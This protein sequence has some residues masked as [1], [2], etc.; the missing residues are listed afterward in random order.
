M[1]QTPSTPAKSLPHTSSLF[2]ILSNKK[3]SDDLAQKVVEKDKYIELLINILKE[4]HIDIPNFQEIVSSPL[5]TVE[6]LKTLVKD[7]SIEEIE[8]VISAQ[9]EY[10]RKIDITVEFHNLT[11]RTN[12]KS[13][14]EIYSIGSILKNLFCFWKSFDKKIEVNILSDLTGRILPRKMT[15]LIGPPGSGKSGTFYSLIYLFI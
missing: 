7:G 15:L 10:I 2:N 12:I 6:H 4:N 11:Y 3:L 5:L 13:K 8:T 14:H 1:S 9:K